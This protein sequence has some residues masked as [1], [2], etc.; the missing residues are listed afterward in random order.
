MIVLGDGAT[1]KAEY[2][3]KRYRFLLSDGM[4]LDVEAIRDDS[5]LR[6]AVLKHTKA[7]RIE[8]VATVGEVQP[9]KVIKRGTAPVSSRS[10]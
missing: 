10:R 5:D 9:T 8:G 7:A 6:E 2:P 1:C 4:T 3:W